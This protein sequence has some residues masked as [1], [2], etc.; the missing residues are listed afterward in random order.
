M[1]RD[2]TINP[3]G[4]SIEIRPVRARFEEFFDFTPHREALD[5]HATPASSTV[6]I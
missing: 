5:S 2:C 6:N 3:K 4:K 1:W